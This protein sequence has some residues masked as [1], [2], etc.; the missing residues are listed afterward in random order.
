MHLLFLRP[1]G[2]VGYGAHDVPFCKTCGCVF[3]ICREGARLPPF[4]NVEFNVKSGRTQGPPLPCVVTFA[5]Q[6]YNIIPSVCGT[7]RTVQC[8]MI[9]YRECNMIVYSFVIK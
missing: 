3:D 1:Y 6:I 2:T 4:A 9:V 8:S 5:H 7:S